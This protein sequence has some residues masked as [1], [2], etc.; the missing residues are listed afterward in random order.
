MES[1][2][3]GYYV[4]QI[5]HS[6]RTWIS[7]VKERTLLELEKLVVAVVSLCVDGN[8][9]NSLR[10]WDSCLDSMS[11]DVA[12]MVTLRLLWSLGSSL[13]H[14]FDASLAPP[15]G[16]AKENQLFLITETNALRCECIEGQELVKQSCIS[17]VGRFKFVSHFL[18]S[19]KSQRKT[20]KPSAGIFTLGLS[21]F[22]ESTRG[23]RPPPS[24]LITPV[25]C[26]HSNYL[27]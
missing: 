9:N 2:N 11:N 22:S 5:V 18:M 23:T 19:W 3:S 7:A 15:T 10:L 17:H 12:V 26:F 20:I 6:T 21:G 8:Q 27:G 25:T 24:I 16:L 14:L 4:D 13:R 1:F